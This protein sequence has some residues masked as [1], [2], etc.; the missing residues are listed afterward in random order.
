MQH[1]VAGYGSQVRIGSS[2]HSKFK[3]WLGNHFFKQV[4]G[5]YNACAHAA[6]NRLAA[7]SQRA[8]EDGYILGIKLIVTV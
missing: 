3:S 2:V 4:G 6:G 8:A 7:T 1:R 5:V